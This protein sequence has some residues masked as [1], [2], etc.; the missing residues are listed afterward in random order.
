MPR[1]DGNGRL[2]EQCY[3]MRRATR[4]T[5]HS[6]A[7]FGLHV[8]RVCL[9]LM[10]LAAQ[11]TLVFGF[12][13]P[14]YRSI[15]F[16]FSLETKHALDKPLGFSARSSFRLL[17]SSS[18]SY[19]RTQRMLPAVLL[20]SA[21]RRS[22]QHASPYALAPAAAAL[23][24][25]G[26][27]SETPPL[28]VKQQQQ[29]HHHHHDLAPAQPWCMRPQSAP[30]TIANIHGY[31]IGSLQT[32]CYS[33]LGSGIG[34]SGIGGSGIGEQPPSDDDEGDAAAAAA[35]DDPVRAAVVAEVAAALESFGLRP[36]SRCVLGGGLAAVDV[37][38]LVGDPPVQ[39][40]GVT[41]CF[42][43]AAKSG[44]MGSCCN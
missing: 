19:A 1:R 34:G 3:G 8:E 25:L 4:Y 17:F 37:G 5:Q 40:R 15:R 30:A 31:S 44:C 41:L 11:C 7:R 39:V 36:G 18:A 2:T 6:R 14:D 10:C 42:H 27:V 29:Q 38:V 22:T 32:S 20:R 28:T 21:L 16:K 23:F 43:A 35:D 26:A 9:F 13:H 33:T 24:T 12:G